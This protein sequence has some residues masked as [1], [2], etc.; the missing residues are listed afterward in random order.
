MRVARFNLIGVALDLSPLR[1]GDPNVS[2]TVQRVQSLLAVIRSVIQRG[3]LTSVQA[4]SLASKLGFALCTI[5][6]AIWPLPAAPHSSQS[7]LA[8]A[9]PL[10]KVTR[11]SAL[12][13]QVSAGLPA[14]FYPKVPAS[15]STFD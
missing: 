6:W 10:Q 5:L 1:F 11:M 3:R 2:I 12:V 15:L 14:T 4:D 13:D 8:Q 7:L 9:K